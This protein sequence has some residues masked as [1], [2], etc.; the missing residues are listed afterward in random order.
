MIDINIS[1]SID[2]NEFSKL[3]ITENLNSRNVSQ[4]KTFLGV[5]LFF[6]ESRDN[7][8][9][10]VEVDARI[11]GKMKRIIK[12]AT[13]ANHYDAYIEAIDKAIEKYKKMRSVGKVEELS[14]AA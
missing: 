2:I 14:I 8:K 1:S 7:V 6:T 4:H 10:I 11:R 9:A 3:S 5:K 12:K 13:G